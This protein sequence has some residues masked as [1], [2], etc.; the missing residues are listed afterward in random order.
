LHIQA[1][2]DLSIL[3]DQGLD[4]AAYKAELDALAQQI[5]LLKADTITLKGDAPGLTA[6]RQRHEAL[7][8][9]LRNVLKRT[10]SD[11]QGAPELA[12]LRGFGWAV[13]AVA[14]V[15]ALGTVVYLNRRKMR[16]RR[17]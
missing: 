6:W 3:A 5:S 9:A 14:A 4:V 10:G 8:K 17:R 7:E 2:S 16:R 12:M 11:R 13:V 15:A 1:I